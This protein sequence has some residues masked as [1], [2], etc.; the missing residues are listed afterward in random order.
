MTKRTEQLEIITW[1]DSWHG[2]DAATERDQVK[3]NKFLVTVG[4]LVRENKDEVILCTE[5]AMETGDD[6]VRFANGIVKK[7][8]IKRVSRPISFPEMEGENN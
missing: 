5:T 1:R 4:F 7:N 3:G 6:R 2:Y 8:I